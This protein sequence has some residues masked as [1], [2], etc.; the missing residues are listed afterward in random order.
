MRRRPRQ[1]RG[2]KTDLRLPGLRSQDGGSWP[3]WTHP[4]TGLRYELRVRRAGELSGGQ[5]EACFGL[6]QATSGHDYRASAAG[7][8]PAAKRREMASAELR[9]VL[10]VQ[11]GEEKEE[12][13][14]EEGGDARVAG[15]TSMMATF[16]GGEPVVYCYEIHLEPALQGWVASPAPLHTHRR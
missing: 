11:A 12:E 8:H 13:G 2:N 1:G 5:M 4:R 6:V 16:E 15:F 14:E 7:W 3:E 10:V 9:Y